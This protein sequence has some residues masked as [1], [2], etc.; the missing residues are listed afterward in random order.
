[1][2]RVSGPHA[3][4]AVFQIILNC[5]RERGDE[6]CRVPSAECRVLVVRPPRHSALGTRHWNPNPRMLFYERLNVTFIRKNEKL[7]QHL[8][9]QW[10]GSPSAFSQRS[11]TPHH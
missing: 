9:Y 6:K 11:C 5:G 4:S 2:A 7:L 10:Y 8:L 3:G 1:M